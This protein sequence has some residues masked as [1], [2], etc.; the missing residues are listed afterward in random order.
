[1]T[2]PKTVKDPE[3][4]DQQ[5]VENGTSPFPQELVKQ[6]PASAANVGQEYGVQ[7]WDQP[8]TEDRIPYG[9]R[10]EGGWHPELEY[11]RQFEKQNALLQNLF[12]AVSGRARPALATIECQ[13]NA[14]R[15]MPARMTLDSIIA[16]NLTGAGVTAVLT[17]GTRTYTFG[18]QANQTLLLPLPLVIENG[19]DV[20]FT[21]ASGW[22][23]GIL[24]AARS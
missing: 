8:P 1:M 23:V 15:I 21:N 9:A 24:S 10:T 6:G 20:T 3:D 19:T 2:L 22:L 4:L 7:P 11:I 5:G 16:T 18:L 13:L 12:D 14:R 17:L